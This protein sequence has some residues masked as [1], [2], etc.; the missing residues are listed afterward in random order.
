MSASL[1]GMKKSGEMRKDRNMVPVNAQE[2][3]RTEVS[4]AM[5]TET[6]TRL[7]RRV[8]ELAENSTRR[9]DKKNQSKL[10]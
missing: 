10:K 8:D 6:L 1:V 4:K 2:Q 5:V 7:E 9:K 3:N